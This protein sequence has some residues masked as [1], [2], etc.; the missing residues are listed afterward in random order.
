MFCNAKGLNCDLGDASDIS[1]VISHN[2]NAVELF[3]LREMMVK[4]AYFRI[5]EYE[6]IWRKNHNI[7]DGA[8]STLFEERKR[9]TA[10]AA[11]E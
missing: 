6:Q 7:P 5:D 3:G 4:R 1:A 10:A 11:A 8:P 2:F 9:K